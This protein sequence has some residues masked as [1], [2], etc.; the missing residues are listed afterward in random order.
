VSGRFGSASDRLVCR[1][2]E[3]PDCTNHCITERT[4]QQPTVQCRDHQV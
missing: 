4:G 2:H 3:R 1:H